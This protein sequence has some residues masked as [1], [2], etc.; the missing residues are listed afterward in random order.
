[1]EVFCLDN[2]LLFNVKIVV[3]NFGYNYIGR[4]MIESAANLLDAKAVCC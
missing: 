2:C 3:V 1:V 4:C